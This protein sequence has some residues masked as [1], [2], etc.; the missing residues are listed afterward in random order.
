MRKYKSDFLNTL[1]ERGYIHQCSDFDGLDRLAAK[2]D[3]IAYVGY[4]CTAP[5]LHSGHLLS[6]MMLHWLQQ[7]G[8]QRI[9]LLGSGT[10]RVGDPSGKYDTLPILP[11]ETTET[12]KQAIKGAFSRFL[13]FGEGKA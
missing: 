9:A 4:D 13:R 6:I 1:D 12:N 11:I 8:G 2:G 5:S 10:T 7:T 3:V